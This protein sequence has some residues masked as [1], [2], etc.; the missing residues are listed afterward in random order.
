MAIKSQQF[1]KE[2]LKIL[3]DYTEEVIDGINEKTGA[4]SRA[5]VKTLKATSPKQS[6]DYGKSWSL[7]AQ[8][9]YNAPTRYT[10]HNKEHY[11]LTHLLEY[12]HAINGGT[13]RVKPQSHIKAVEEQVVGD[14]TKAV[15]EVIKNGG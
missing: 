1:T 14:Y 9:F 11:R 2:I 10:I 3:E 5:A 7:K 4:I 6:G 13:D 15:E 8:K 12:G